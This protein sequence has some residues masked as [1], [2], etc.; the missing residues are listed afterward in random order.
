M[1]LLLDFVNTEKWDYDKIKQFYEK[2]RIGHDLIR[3]NEHGF[4]LNPN[5]LN[6]CRQMLE[7][8]CPIRPSFIGDIPEIF[9]QFITHAE[10]TVGVGINTR[11][12]LFLTVRTILAGP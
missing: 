12:E 6:W 4:N 9:S 7:H 8:E 11:T 1:Q 3:S 2:F 10:Q 5:V